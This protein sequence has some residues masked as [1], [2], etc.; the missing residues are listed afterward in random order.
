M[1]CKFERK[2]IWASGARTL[3]ET[4]SLLLSYD[5]KSNMLWTLLLGLFVLWVL[6]LIGQVGSGF[7]QLLLVVALIVFLIE[8]FSRSR[9]A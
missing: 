9:V 1:N 3:R 6:G 4:M 2:L 5:G 7:V 8:L